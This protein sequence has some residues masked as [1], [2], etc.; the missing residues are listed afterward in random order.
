VQLIDP[1]STGG[2]RMNVKVG[3]PS[4]RSSS[5]P[6]AAASSEPVPFVLDGARDRWLVLFFY[7]RDFTVRLPNR[8]GGVRE[9]EQAFRVEDADVVAA[10]TDS[11][12]SHKAWF[13]SDRQLG[14]VDF[15]VVADTSH[16]LSFDF[17]VLTTTARRCA[18]PSS[19]TRPASSVTPA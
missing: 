4:R 14:A 15:P 18:G 8:T 11:Y 5:R 10:S 13:E 17:G 1:V 2:I 12:W 9:L 6:I 3:S 16:Q 19:S 7:P